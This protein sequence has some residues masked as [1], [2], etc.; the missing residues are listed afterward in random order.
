MTRLEQR[1]NNDFLA[2]LKAHSGRFWHGPQCPRHL[3]IED[4]KWKEIKAAQEEDMGRS[5]SRWWTFLKCRQ[6]EIPTH[7]RG[8]WGP[9]VPPDVQ[10]AK[11]SARWSRWFARLQEK[12]AE[13]EEYYRARRKNPDRRRRRR[14]QT[15]SEGAP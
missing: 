13:L 5:F 15:A 10:R 4:M 14:R 11:G 1:E 3:P 9:K 12:P 2:W 8:G 6:H 7:G